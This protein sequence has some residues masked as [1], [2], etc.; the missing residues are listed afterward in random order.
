MIRQY[1]ASRIYAIRRELLAKRSGLVT[2][3]HAARLFETAGPAHVET[4]ASLRTKI[5]ELTADAAPTP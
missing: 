3:S 5:R 1:Y 4:V 2:L